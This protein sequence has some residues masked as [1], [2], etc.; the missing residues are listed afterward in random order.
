M[1]DERRDDTAD[2][3]R[4]DVYSA[5]VSASVANDAT[6]RRRPRAGARAD[7]PKVSDK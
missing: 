6:K 3:R 1:G 7:R 2:R 5:V 4:A